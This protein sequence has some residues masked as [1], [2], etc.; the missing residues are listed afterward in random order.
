VITAARA[1]QLLGM[2][3]GEAPRAVAFVLAAELVT[4][5]RIVAGCCPVTHSRDFSRGED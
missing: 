4:A 2:A 3:A 5:R 1:T